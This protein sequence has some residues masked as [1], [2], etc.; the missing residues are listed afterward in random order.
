MKAPHIVLIEDNPG[1]VMLVRLALKENDIQHTLTHFSSGAD[2][3]RVLCDTSSGTASVP[4]VILLDLNTP[5]MDG[6]EAVQRF[7][8][9][10][11]LSQIPL[12]ILT[13]SRASVDK[14]RAEELGA[15]F[16]EKPTQLQDFLS[17]V[18]NA[19]KGMLERVTTSLP[20][21]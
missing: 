10:P 5:Q 4:D 13:S 15:D 1:D 7:K 6:F 8:D 3:V 12:A 18:G 19:V 9:S 14:R 2:A 20:G 11:Q 16:I 21:R 17:S